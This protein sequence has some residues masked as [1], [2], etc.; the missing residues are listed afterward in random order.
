MVFGRAIVGQES[1]SMAE[2][3]LREQRRPPIG[4]R[5]GELRLS[6]CL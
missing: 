5:R 4:R 1:G 2:G 6:L 3:G